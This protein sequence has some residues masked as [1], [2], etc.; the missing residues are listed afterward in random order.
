[1]KIPAQ[2]L[3]LSAETASQYP[4]WYEAP[5]TDRFFW[6]EKSLQRYPGKTPEDTYFAHAAKYAEFG[7]IICLSIGFIDRTQN[8]P[9]MR[10]KS[11]QGD[12]RDILAHFFRIV[13]E[14]FQANRLI[15]CAHNGKEFDFPY[16]CRRAT[17]LEL[18]LPASLRLE[19]KKPWEVQHWD[20]L[21]FWK[22]GDRK[23]YISL[24]LLAHVLQISVP[25]SPI[26]AQDV[27]TAYHREQDEEKISQFSKRNVLL[28]TQIALKLKKQKAVEEV[29]FI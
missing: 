25:E 23:H 2:L 19:N 29:V 16:I 15:L 10:I 13:E 11:L 9:R 3:T 18:E 5:E 21:D 27:N 26:G 14:R 22:F 28:T 4:S 8:E 20:T 7:K 17:A 12:E 1:M 24:E 6:E